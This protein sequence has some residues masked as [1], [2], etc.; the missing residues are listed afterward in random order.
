MGD[1]AS[2][3]YVR[4][5][6]AGPEFPPT[7]V[8]KIFTGAPI[9]DIGAFAPRDYRRASG[10]WYER[11]ENNGWRPI[12]SARLEEVL[13]EPEGG[14]R[15]APAVFYPLRAVRRAHYEQE[16]K[17][18]KRQWMQQLYRMGREGAWELEA[19]ELLQWSKALDFDRYYL[20][21]S[22]LATTQ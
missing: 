15:R 21:W 20:S 22:Q 13:A 8:Y 18:R 3:L 4:F 7:V 16:R 6:L 10:R 19:D 5:R 12:A 17:Q 14:K 11:V 1:A 9:T 2:R